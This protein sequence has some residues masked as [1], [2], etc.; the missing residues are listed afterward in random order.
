RAGD[1][2]ARRAGPALAARHVDD[3]LAELG[4]DLGVESALAALPPLEVGDRF[5]RLLEPAERLRARRMRRPRDDVELHLLLIELAPHL[6]AAGYIE[7]AEVIHVIHAE[8]AS[9][10]PGEER[11]RR[12]LADPVVRD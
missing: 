9:R 10:R 12:A 1:P 7:P 2:A 8:G 3:A 5:Q 4:I 6:E 11:H